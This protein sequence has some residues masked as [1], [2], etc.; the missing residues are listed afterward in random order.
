MIGRPELEQGT[1]FPFQ[2]TE[3]GLSTTSNTV[4]TFGQIATFSEISDSDAEDPTVAMQAELD[5]MKVAVKTL[6]K[7]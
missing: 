5:P 2:G 7:G 1:V 4:E 3:D 6:R